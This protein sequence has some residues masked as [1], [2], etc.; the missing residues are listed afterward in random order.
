MSIVDVVAADIRDNLFSGLLAGRAQLTEA[1]V[2]TSYGV[3]RPTAKAAIEKLVAEGL[4]HRGTHKTAHVPEL[5]PDDVRDLYFARHCIETQVVRRLAEQQLVPKSALTANSEVVARGKSSESIIEPVVGFH[6][7]LVGAIG[8]PRLARLF[9]SLMGEMR[10]CMAQMQS[11]H[12]LRGGP[13]A[14]EHRRILD[15]ITAGDPDG[16]V[17]ALVEHLAMAERRLLAGSARAKA[18]PEQAEAPA[19]QLP[20]AEANGRL[21]R[22]ASS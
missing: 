10:L 14:A 11:K 7:A 17:A 9:R 6:S 19:Q 2:A 8:S 5:G 3:A 16:A 15:C 1:E 18:L 20:R 13:I 12:L 21:P 22:R 4:L